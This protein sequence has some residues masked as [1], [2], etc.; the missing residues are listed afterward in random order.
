MG[1]II[2]DNRGQVTLFPE[3]LDEYI[4]E[5]NPAQVID[6]F[7]N[8]LDLNAAGFRNT[9][10]AKEGRPSYNP[11]LL[12]KLYIYGYFNKIRSSRKLMAEC[13]RNVEVMW[14]L[15]KL[16]PDFRTIA[17]FRKDNA[18]AMKKVFRAF[19]KICIELDLYTRELVAID[20][21]KFRAVNSKDNNV[22]ITKLEDKLKRIEKNVNEY[23]EELDRYDKDEDGIKDPGKEELQKKLEILKS[24]KETYN[25]YLEEMKENNGTQKSFID[26]ES[27]L[28]LTHSGGFEVCYNVQ[29]AVDAGNHMIV[30]F[31][32]TNNCTDMGLLYE[33]A[34]R[35]KKELGTE[36]LEVV[37][38][39]G[40]ESK[41]D[42]LECLKV[43]IIPNVALKN[44]ATECEIG[45]LY[46]ESE[47]TSEMLNSTKPED[48]Q[49]CLEAGILP[50]LY[51][52][53][54]IEIEVV[55]EIKN[56]PSEKCFVLNED[57]ESVTC[58]KGK[59]LN[60]AAY[61][62]NKSATR[63]AS[64][65]ACGNCDDKCTTA[66]F[67]Q[68]DLKDGQKTLYLKCSNFTER[69]V[70]IRLKAD[71][72]KLKKR[73]CVVEHPFGTIKRWCDGS[74]MLMKGK[75][76]STADLSLS[77]LAYNIKRAIKIIGVERL[78]EAII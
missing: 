41:E 33:D 76:K 44:D 27:R 9:T 45:L 70:I 48:I 8:N 67:K 32:V 19:A 35:A 1:Y 4:S 20:G 16:M 46:K 62:G 59:I 23:L 17:D 55:E 72:E 31:E 69:K 65:F 12:L 24:R 61:L 52:N 51:I 13:G 15:C 18:K 58:P 56:G 73:K 10:P 36:I 64:R 54:N 21:S 57:T 49:K 37:A 7:V 78:V 25:E 68:V 39:K 43:G 77:F 47:I 14:L 71:K 3:T 75:I 63:F 74:Y 6:A 26:P 53:K 60:K 28:M 50:A 29:T 40:Y 2:G 11:R 38:D 30:D 22:T 42:M 34:V 66:K 5:S